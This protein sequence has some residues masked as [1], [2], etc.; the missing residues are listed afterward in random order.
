MSNLLDFKKTLSV[1]IPTLNEG[2]RIERTIKSVFEFVTEVI[3]VDGGSSDQTQFCARKTSAK[4]IS[5]ERGRGTQLACGTQKAKSEWLLI[6]HADTVLQGRWWE[7][8]YDFTDRN[9]YNQAAVFKFALK[10][11]NKLARLIEKGVGLRCKFFSLP[12]GDQGLLINRNFLLELGGYKSFPIF[13]D[14]ELVRRIGRKRL[15]LLNC[16]AVTSAKK[17]R[18][19]GYFIRPAK[20]L[21]LLVFY[22][23]GF[24]PKFLEKFYH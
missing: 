12:Y 20:N 13:E 9:S 18:E 7:E 5:S 21:F 3:V 10:D 15:S 1:I 14:V 24:P 2:E 8:V 17:Y 22:F 19:T 16:H 4:V 11:S 6:L 23:M